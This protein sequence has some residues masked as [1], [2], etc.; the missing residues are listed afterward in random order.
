MNCLHRRL[1]VTLC[2]LLVSAAFAQRP[3]AFRSTVKPD[4]LG[5]QLPVPLAALT[6]A[7]AIH[8]LTPAQQQ[9]LCRQ[10]FLVVP[11]RVEQ[12]FY[13]YEEYPSEGDS[14]IPNFVTVDSV[15]YAYHLFYDFTLR[16][17]ESKHLYAAAQ[18]MTNIGLFD[19]VKFHKR[20]QAG[21]LRDAAASDAVYFAI[22]KSLISGRPA[23]TGLGAAADK[24]VTQELALIQAHAGRRQSPLLGTTVHYDQFV[25]RGHYTRS[26]GLRKYFMAMMWYGQIGL[27]LDDRNEALARRQTRMALLITRMLVGDDQLRALWAKVYEP[28]SFYVG[29]SDDLGYEQYAAVARG[30]FGAEVESMISDMPRGSVIVLENTRFEAGETLNDPRVAEGLASLAHVFVSD[31]FGTAHR[32]PASTGG[33]ATKLP[34]VAGR[35][36]APYVRTS[37]YTWPAMIAV[38]PARLPAPC[39]PGH[40]PLFHPAPPKPPEPGPLR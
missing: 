3:D 40:R 11:D 16:T 30:V 18:K 35:L 20:L 8:K 19:S 25:P 33:V 4:A 37:L 34:S 36:L 21:P 27:V 14:P 28:T 23:P 2:L 1:I 6:N 38:G 39:R 9:R 17:I 31:A 32:A 12:M 5:Y 24:L 29:A 13:L 26:E 22:A 7:Q 10:G 15:L